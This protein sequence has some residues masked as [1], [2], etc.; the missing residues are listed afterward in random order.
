MFQKESSRF[1]RLALSTH[2]GPRDLIMR[3]GPE[4]A[5]RRVMGRLLRRHALPRQ[6]V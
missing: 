2:V 6:L 5:R 1:A 3:V 4:R